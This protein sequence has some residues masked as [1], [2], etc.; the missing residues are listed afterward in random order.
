MTTHQGDPAQ[1]LADHLAE[2]TGADAAIVADRNAD[3]VVA[4]LAAAGW[5]LDE[6][7]EFIAGKRIRMMHPPQKG[8]PDSPSVL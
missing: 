2:C 5:T 6:G 7:A 3:D 4:S 1:I 8:A